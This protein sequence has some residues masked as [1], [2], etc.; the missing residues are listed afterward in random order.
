MALKIALIIL[1]LSVF[2]QDIKYRAVYWVLF[3]IMLILQFFIALTYYSL[4]LVLLNGMYNLIFI[5]IQFLLITVYF[6]LKNKKLINISTNYLGWGDIIFLLVISFSFSPLN[7]LFFYITSLCLIVTVS[8]IFHFK[9]KNDPIKIPL[10]G[11]QS[12]YLILLSFA[13][14]FHKNIDLQNDDFLLHLICM[15]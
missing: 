6:S 7:Y 9:S 8:L 10:A 5:V 12:A 1:L 14:I 11:L 3:P 4:Q 13:G 2:Y 15:N